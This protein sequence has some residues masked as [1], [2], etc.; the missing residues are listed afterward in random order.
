MLKELSWM[1]AFGGLVLLPCA[2]GHAAV[3]F[4][5]PAT[6]A[7]TCAAK[8]CNNLGASNIDSTKKDI[9]FCLSSTANNA[10]CSTGLC[11]WL[12]SGGGEST[13][14]P[15]S[16]SWH[17]V[18]SQRHY[19]ALYGQSGSGNPSGFSSCVSTCYPPYSNYTNNTGHA[20]KVEVTN[21]AA[22]SWLTTVFFSINDQLFGQD[23]QVPAATSVS[24]FIVPP[25][26]RYGV[27]GSKLVKWR[28]F[29]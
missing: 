12:S 14:F 20:I 4:C 27:A 13:G 16:A 6:S 5:D 21:A 29:Y 2:T 9:L 8:P 24:T 23:S 18:T 19:S 1:A 25:G 11:K 10:D 28:E 22:G 7:T 26:V 17:D 15:A 3:S